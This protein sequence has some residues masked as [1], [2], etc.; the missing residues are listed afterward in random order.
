MTI[1]QKIPFLSTLLKRKLLFGEVEGCKPL[2]GRSRAALDI[3]M[4][5]G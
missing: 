2:N 1:A 5:R 3:F 4:V